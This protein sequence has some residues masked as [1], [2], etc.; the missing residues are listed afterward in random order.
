M[1]FIA[2]ATS[3]Q[4]QAD[5]AN[6]TAYAPIN[7]KS[8]ALLDTGPGAAAAGSQHAETQINLDMNYWAEHRDEI[9]ERWY[10]WQAK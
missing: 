5:L 7:L 3:A 4:G 8:E 1:K 6:A 10:A 2:L 9:G